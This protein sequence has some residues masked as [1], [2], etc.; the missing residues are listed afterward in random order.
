MPSQVGHRHHRITPFGTQPHGQTPFKEAIFLGEAEAVGVRSAAR[1]EKR[2]IFQEYG[3]R[4]PYYG[5]QVFAKVP[6]DN[7]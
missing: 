6:P 5:G 1:L 3:Y 7:R 4:F 2:P